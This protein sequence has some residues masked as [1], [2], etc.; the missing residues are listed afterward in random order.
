M[1]D[2]KWQGDSNMLLQKRQIP[3]WHASMRVAW[4]DV[5]SAQHWW[6]LWTSS[7]G[8][9]SY[10]SR[11][12]QASWKVDLKGAKETVYIWW[13]NIEIIWIIVQIRT[14]GAKAK[15]ED[16]SSREENVA[17][18]LS[19]CGCIWFHGI[20]KKEQIHCTFTRNFTLCHSQNPSLANFS[21]P[22]KSLI[23]SP[24]NGILKEQGFFFNVYWTR[25]FSGN[26]AFTQASSN[27]RKDLWTRF[28]P[29][30]S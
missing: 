1:K 28:R 25:E 16:I 6:G 7:Y 21:F 10:K 4:S 9:S 15:E 27:I 19:L 5:H 24:L 3:P 12:M 20:W 13:G 30:V 23:M 11:K 2:H 14:E 8:F 29:G 18:V 26:L 22:H 17:N